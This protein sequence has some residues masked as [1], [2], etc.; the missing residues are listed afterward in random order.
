MTTRDRLGCV[1][2]AAVAGWPA[3]Y[4]LRRSETPRMGSARCAP[5]RRLRPPRASHIGGLGE[6]P[7]SP[8]RFSSIL[9]RA[10]SRSVWISVKNSAIGPSS[11]TRTSSNG[12][13]LCHIDQAHGPG[14]PPAG[15]EIPGDDGLPTRRRCTSGLW[16]LPHR[17]AANESGCM[18]ARDGIPA[19]VRFLVALL[20]SLAIEV[21]DAAGAC[22]HDES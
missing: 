18:N 22:R 8:G 12:L 3:L 14:R 10:R 6:P 7:R 4:G 9:A 17:P 19:L 20:V 2:I 15:S 1:P 11:Q 16:Y 21:G 5:Q 13:T